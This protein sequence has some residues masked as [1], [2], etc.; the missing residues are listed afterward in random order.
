MESMIAMPFHPSNVYTV[1]E[2]CENPG[3]IL[4]AVEKQASEQMELPDG[5]FRLTDKIVGDKIRVDQ[6]VIA[7]CAGGTFDNL[8]AAAAILK[9]RFHR[10]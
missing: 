10:L 1:R 7:G 5:L 9:N 3:D 8:C 4:R 6:G 2:V